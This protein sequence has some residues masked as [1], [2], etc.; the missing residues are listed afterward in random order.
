MLPVEAFES[1]SITI[2]WLLQPNS[3]VLWQD[4]HRPFLAGAIFLAVNVG[5]QPSDLERG[6]QSARS[7]YRT[8][9]IACPDPH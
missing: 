1:I 2:P 3:H 5:Y 7:Y 6:T 9:F 4:I 8:R